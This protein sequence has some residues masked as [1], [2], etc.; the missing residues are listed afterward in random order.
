[1]KTNLN[2]LF[3]DMIRNYAFLL[4]TDNM[5]K[6]EF[7]DKIA[8]MYDMSEPRNSL[9]HQSILRSEFK[10]IRLSDNRESILFNQ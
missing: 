2:Y 1:M 5:T 6:V 10:T 8:S 9:F 3:V 4:T 7:A